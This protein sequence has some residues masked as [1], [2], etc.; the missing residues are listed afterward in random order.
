MLH[1]LR[2]AGIT[3]RA[4]SFSPFLH[5]PHYL[6]NFHHSEACFPTRQTEGAS[7][8][9]SPGVLV[10]PGCQVRLKKGRAAD[11]YARITLCFGTGDCDVSI[12][13]FSLSTEDEGM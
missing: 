7:Y 9:A 1:Q 13:Q 12:S 5:S 3:L 4:S 8:H 10:S 6:N 2:R 11:A